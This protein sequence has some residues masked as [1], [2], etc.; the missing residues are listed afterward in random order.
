MDS[1]QVNASNGMIH[2]RGESVAIF[3]A[4]GH[5]NVGLSP[6]PDGLVEVWFAK[7]LIGHLDPKTSSFSAITPPTPLPTA[8]RQASFWPSPLRSEAQKDASL[9]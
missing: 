4:L 7:L 9:T 1:R 8:T 2:Y 6:R 3:T 5:W